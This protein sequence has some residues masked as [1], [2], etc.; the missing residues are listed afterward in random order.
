MKDAYSFDV[1][2]EDAAFSYNKFFFFLFK[3]I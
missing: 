1:N 2:D 3:N